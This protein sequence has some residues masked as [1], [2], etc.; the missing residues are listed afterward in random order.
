MATALNNAPPLHT[1]RR[2]PAPA[3][4]AT[5][6]PCALPPELAHILSSRTRIEALAAALIDLLDGMD[7]PLADLEPDVDLEDEPDCCEAADDDPQSCAARQR[8][9]W[10]CPTGQ[11]DDDEED[12]QLYPVMGLYKVAAGPV[13]IE[14]G[15]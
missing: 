14:G 15:P 13:R 12:E 11:D 5:R 10:N 8:S 1:S 2:S 9:Q 7:A 3:R 6:R 4:R